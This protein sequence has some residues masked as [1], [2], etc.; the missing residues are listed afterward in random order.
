[1][2]SCCAGNECVE[3]SYNSTR[4][5]RLR[6]RSSKQ[7]KAPENITKDKVITNHVVNI[8]TFYASCS[9]T[10]FTNPAGCGQHTLSTSF[11]PNRVTGEDSVRAW[12]YSIQTIIYDTI[13]YDMQFTLRRVRLHLRR[14]SRTMRAAQDDLGSGQRSGF[15]TLF[16]FSA[17]LVLPATPGIR[18]G[19]NPTYH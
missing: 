5:E 10:K 7:E 6:K 13:L 12:E 2:Y 19:C 3:T 4:K 8:H 1:M 14:V 9:S 17:Y 18:K 15:F 16:T 11:V